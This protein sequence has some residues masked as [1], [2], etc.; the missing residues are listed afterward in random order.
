M[1]RLFS[2]DFYGDYSGMEKSWPLR[3]ASVGGDGLLRYSG[4]IYGCGRRRGSRFAM[5]LRRHENFEEW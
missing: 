5:L 2:M 4:S 3:A 1:I